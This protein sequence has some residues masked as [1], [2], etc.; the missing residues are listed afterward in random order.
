MGNANKQGYTIKDKE[1]KSIKKL[2]KD[3][4]IDTDGRKDGWNDHRGMLLGAKI[5]ITSVRKYENKWSWN[6][7]NKFC[8]EVDIEVDITE[9]TYMGYSGSKYSVRYDLGRG[10]RCTNNYYR[11]SYEKYVIDELKLK[12]DKYILLTNLDYYNEI[13]YIITLQ[14]LAYEISISKNINPDKPR[15]LAKV[16]S[17]E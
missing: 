9:S 10:I 17:V 7:Q 15:N 16:V 12:Q 13:L 11:S 5:K 6:G 3:M 14:K 1:I 8:Y 4:I 2:V